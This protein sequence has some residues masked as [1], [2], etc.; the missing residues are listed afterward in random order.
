MGIVHTCPT[1]PLA[2]HNWLL[3]GVVSGGCVTEAVKLAPS[4][5]LP[6]KIKIRSK[7]SV[8]ALGGLTVLGLEREPKHFS[9]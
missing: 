8:L 4:P 6:P 7:G 5:V 1:W 3:H 2:L 9:H